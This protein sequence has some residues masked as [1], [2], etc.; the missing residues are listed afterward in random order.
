MFS[1]QTLG[2]L[3]RT[4]QS[5][6]LSARA[7]AP[8]QPLAPTQAIKPIAPET[9]PSRESRTGDPGS[10]RARAG[11]APAAPG[12]PAAGV[13]DDAAAVVALGGHAGRAAAPWRPDAAANP[14]AYVILDGAADDAPHGVQARTPAALALAPPA[15]SAI[16]SAR[17]AV[18][19]A[20][21]SLSTAGHLVDMLARL[22]GGAPIRPA[23]PLV[24]QPAAAPAAIAHALQQSI[25]ASGVFYESH[26]ARWT[27]QRT[28][29][30]ALLEQ[31]QARWG[32]STAVA[33]PGAVPQSAPA[34]WPLAAPDGEVP[35][36]SPAGLPGA[37]PA[38]AT[39]VPE[40]AP[41]LVRQQLEALETGQILWRGDLWP[42]QSAA[43]EITDDERQRAPGQAPAW[44]TRLNLTLPGLGPIEAR[45]ALSGQRI[46]LELGADNAVC[47]ASLAAAL[48]ELA[49]ALGERGLELAPVRIDH[50]GEP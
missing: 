22:P 13:H 4:L 5:G 39:G 24:P 25:V 33:D 29:P 28:S 16:P 8:L 35:A 26:L 23:A 15:A 21:L 20:L 41:S 31:P 1:V 18:G 27:L 2:T 6:D 11:M 32:P 46:H 14:A 45:L 3:L 42:G 19:A 9:T 44:R 50:G 38:A 17:P 37:A 48:P 49:M 43:I 10:P 7:A 47:A 36:A 40:A 30:A 34:P 12:P